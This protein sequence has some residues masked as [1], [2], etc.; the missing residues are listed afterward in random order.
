MMC[1]NKTTEN[2][3]ILHGKRSEWRPTP[4]HQILHGKRSE[5]GPITLEAPCSSYNYEILFKL[6]TDVKDE[7]VHHITVRIS[8]HI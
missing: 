7:K 4:T 8:Q 3:Q 5:Q 6:L 1:H 2:H